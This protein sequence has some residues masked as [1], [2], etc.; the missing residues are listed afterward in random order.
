LDRH[1]DERSSAEIQHDL[2]DLE[3]RGW[4]ALTSPDG[5]AFY[6]EVLS[7]DAVMVFP[8]TVLTRQES[9]SAIAGAA[10]W[11]SFSLEDVRVLPVGTEG[12]IITY[13]AVANRGA[14]ST[15]DAVMTS[16]YA[17]RAGAWRL[18]LHQQTPSA[19]HS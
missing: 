13:R 2:V 5:A 6:A 3:R 4:E 12:G 17:K 11:S 14:E 1:E 10:P 16:V 15:Y 9:L 7:D 19:R 8:D 18:V